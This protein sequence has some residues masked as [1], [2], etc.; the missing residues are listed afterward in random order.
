MNLENLKKKYPNIYNSVYDG[1][2]NEFNLVIRMV[3]EK[4]AYYACLEHHKMMKKYKKTIPE[5]Q[6]K[7]DC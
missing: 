1:T 6:K 5:I 4:S 3:A 7:R 2:I